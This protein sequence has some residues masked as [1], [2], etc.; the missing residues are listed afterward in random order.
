MDFMGVLD[1]VKN[2]SHH[3]PL[4][5]SFACHLDQPIMF[6]SVDVGSGSISFGP[7]HFTPQDGAG[8]FL[9]TWR[10]R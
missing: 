2:Y 4:L 7:N 10:R 1:T 5:I 3:T 6:Y 9:G 8:P